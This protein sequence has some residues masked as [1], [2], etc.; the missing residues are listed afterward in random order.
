M[1]NCC[2]VVITVEQGAL[3]VVTNRKVALPEPLGSRVGLRVF[4]VPGVMA[5]GP[6]TTLH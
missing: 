5:T 2:K 6:E 3:G 4:S 1:F